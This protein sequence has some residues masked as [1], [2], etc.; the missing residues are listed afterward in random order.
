M[1]R[2]HCRQTLHLS[3]RR[4]IPRP[5]FCYPPPLKSL[6]EQHQ[7]LHYSNSFPREEC[8]VKFPVIIGSGVLYFLPETRPL[9]FQETPFS[10]W[11]PT[12]KCAGKSFRGAR[13][14]GL[15]LNLTF[16]REN[17][18]KEPGRT[19]I[20]FLRGSKFTT[21]SEFTIVQPFT[22]VNPSVRMRSSSLLQ[23]FL[24]SNRVPRRSK[25]G[26][27]SKTR[28]HSNSRYLD[29]IVVLVSRGYSC[30]LLPCKA[31]IPSVTELF[32]NLIQR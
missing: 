9:F 3:R 11:P 29:A 13:K 5:A 7:S 16:S 21:Y 6:Q 19:K 22:I 15:G 1:S 17:R 24:P 28:R 23:R 14:R 4:G 25:S 20:D 18:P 2:H 8:A 32:S 27:R 12:Q 26:G 30:C 31:K 10:N